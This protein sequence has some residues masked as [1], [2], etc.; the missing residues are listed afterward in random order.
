MKGLKNKSEINIAAAKYLHEKDY[1]APSVHCSYYSCLQLIKYSLNSHFRLSEK[2][3]EIKI[4]KYKNTK[5]DGSHN[6]FISYLFKALK[7]TSIKESVDFN[8]KI[9]LL[10][11]H[12]V[13]ADYS[14][15][16]IL[17]N[18]SNSAITL[19]NEITTLLKKN[20]KL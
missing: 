2:E 6:F 13:S 20:L 4:N 15:N 7:S 9:N 3:I 17:Y 8:N 1:Y 18:V 5:K 11:K 19:S 12:R 16:E 10:K 14:K